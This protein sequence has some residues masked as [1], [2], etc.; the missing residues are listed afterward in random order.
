MKSLRI[1]M[2]AA[3]L[4]ALSAVSPAQAE[5]RIGYL[6]TLTGGGAFLGNQLANGWKLAL[7]HEGWTKDGDLLG[8]VPT[9][10]VYGDD[11]QDTDT[12]LSA[13]RKMIGND[14]VHIVAGIVW[15]NVLMAVKGP[16]VDSKRILISSNA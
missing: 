7:E 4:A 2:A 6:T 3:T 9:K 1:T 5:L 12:G 14:K 11:Q 10:M 16:V 8:G 15:S 13:V